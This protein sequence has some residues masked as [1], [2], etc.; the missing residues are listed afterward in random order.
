MMRVIAFLLVI[1]ALLSCS[2]K[3]KS[4]TTSLV[5]DTS[6][7]QREERFDFTDRFVDAAKVKYT[8]SIVTE[9]E[10]YKADSSLG[11]IERLFIDGSINL[12]GIRGAS[13]KSIKQIKI[14][15]HSKSNGTSRERKRS[16]ETKQA[17]STRRE[18]AHQRSQVSVY[19]APYKWRYIFYILLIALAH[20]L[21]L[22]RMPIINWI[23]IVLCGL[24][25]R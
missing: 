19:T 24:I 15:E 3:K 9:I 8:S 7:Q 6:S 1:I 16:S 14:D 22:V 18:H 20:I 21:Y 10:F 25:K 2:S 4:I 13:I 11:N 5:I 12:S 23:R 17:L